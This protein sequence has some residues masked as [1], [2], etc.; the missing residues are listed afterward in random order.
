MSATTSN[1]SRRQGLVLEP[2]DTLF[3]RDGRPFEAATRATSVMPTPQT[4]A[5]ALRT[6][7]LNAAG[8]ELDRL[9]ELVRGEGRS[10][11][12]ALYE[13]DAPASVVEAE[14]RGPW[15]AIRRAE[16]GIEPLLP[17][18][19]T[20]ARDTADGA[21]YRSDPLRK[22]PPGW[23]ET[24]TGT[25]S[26]PLWRRGGAEAKHPGGFL[27]PTGLGRFLEGGVPEDGDWY[28]LDE[29]RVMDHRTGIGIDPKTLSVSEGV[30]YAAGMIA[31]ARAVRG[32]GEVVLYAELAS[33]EALPVGE[34][35]AS[36][37]PLP[38]GGQSRYVGVERAEPVPWPEVEPTDEQSGE[39]RLLITP[40][41]FAAGWR[42]VGLER[43][44]LA[45]A[46]PSPV[47][48]SGWSVPRGGPQRTRFA[49]PAGSVYFFDPSCQ[50]RN[51][52]DVMSDES[53]DRAQGWGV[54]LKGAWNY[55]R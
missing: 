21:W 44:L 52:G 7:L 3:F 13:L 45:A 9:A 17:V 10:I 54:A 4:V 37:G 48:V 29:L 18:P 1:K 20:L 50:N 41:L 25:G 14:M 53:E 31:L 49:A 5:G 40:G 43:E 39:L 36:L 47:P 8:V 26:L 33:E 51:V 32:G 46:V 23:R 15:L 19:A 2:L 16:G 24:D 22:P 28:G 30:I 38:F 27:T 34:D 42:P 55:V 6:S 11:R 12:D 35:L